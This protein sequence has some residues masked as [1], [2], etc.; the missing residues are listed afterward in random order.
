MP[1]SSPLPASPESR[2]TLS[3]GARTLVTFLLILHFFAL[4]VAILSNISRSQLAA[5]LRQIPEPYFSI[6]RMD[7]SY[8]FNFTYGPTPNQVQDTEHWIEAELKLADGNEV[9]V[10]LPPSGLASRQRLGRYE[11]LARQ[12]SAMEIDGAE[13][14]VSLVVAEIARRVVRETRATGGTIRVLEKNLPERP[15]PEAWTPSTKTIY[16]AAIF[17]SDGEVEIQKIASAAE[18]APAARR[19]ETRP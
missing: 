12:V 9:K 8:G 4:G 17:V 3:E 2:F 11:S 5:R 14:I 7:L 15:Y 10:E 1:P 6:L 13:N 16:S 18:S 19:R